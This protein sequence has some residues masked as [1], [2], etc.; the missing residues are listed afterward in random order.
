MSMCVTRM[1][2]KGY[3]S[4]GVKFVFATIRN[5]AKE[6]WWIQAEFFILLRIINPH[7]KDRT[8]ITTVV[9][10]QYSRRGKYNQ[11][12]KKSAENKI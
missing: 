1:Y 10:I 2:M 12:N 9:G 5:V 11:K 3:E 6:M 4:E 7:K 8:I